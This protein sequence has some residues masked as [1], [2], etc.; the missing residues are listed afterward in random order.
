MSNNPYESPSAH[1]EPDRTRIVLE[2]SVTRLTANQ[3]RWLRHSLW[4]LRALFMG[5]GIMALFSAGQIVL[6][7]TVHGPDSPTPISHE[8]RVWITIFDTVFGALAI[9]LTLAIYRL[10]RAIG[11]VREHDAAPAAINR[12]I[13]LGSRACSALGCCAVAHVVMKFLF[14]P[15]WNLVMH[16]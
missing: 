13:R 7:F 9:W 11:H 2:S 16:R 8:D 6:V 14:P 10:N 3:Y 15:I 4:G 5:A 12:A 1:G